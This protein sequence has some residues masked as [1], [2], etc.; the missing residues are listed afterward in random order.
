MRP[1]RLLAGL[2]VGVGLL[3]LLPATPASAH[4][5]GN[6]TVNQHS[7]LVVSHDQITVELV[8]D[9]AE[10]PTFQ[11]RSEI[12]S[13]GDGTVSPCEAGSYRQRACA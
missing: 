9:M 10:I 2:A 1:G 13:D 3:T 7:G 11:T 6:F 8:V 12:D 5:L 4:P